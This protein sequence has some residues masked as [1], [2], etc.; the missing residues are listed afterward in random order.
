MSKIGLG[1]A[2]EKDTTMQG[3]TFITENN[4]QPFN[5]LY[6]SATKKPDYG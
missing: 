5:N 4:S 3:D 6:A 1:Y 2:L